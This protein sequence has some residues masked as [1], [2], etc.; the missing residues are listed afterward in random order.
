MAVKSSGQTEVSQTVKKRSVKR[1]KL[2]QSSGRTTFGQ[3]VKPVSVK[4]SYHSPSCG[5]T[6][7]IRQAVKPRSPTYSYIAYL[8][9]VK[10]WS[11]KR[12]KPNS[13]KRSNRIQSS[14]RTESS[15]A[16]TQR[17][18]ESGQTEVSQVK[19]RQTASPY[20]RNTASSHVAQSRLR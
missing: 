11:V 2:G 13:V 19:N 15:Q 18:V 20:T 1:S 17:P 7:V 12:S 5:Q 3:A 4:R 16:V 14:S 9:A 10:P 8:G 6:E